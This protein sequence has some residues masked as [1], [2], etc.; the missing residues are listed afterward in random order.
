VIPALP[1]LA[2]LLDCSQAGLHEL[3]LSNLD[4]SAKCLKRAKEEIDQAIAHR[5]AA[6]VAR[7][8][9]ENRDELIKLAKRV[10][11]GKQGTLKFTESAPVRLV[12]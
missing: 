10:A 8:L 2:Y 9:I 1:N 7:W 12:A 6:G 11:D 5:E 3:E 4:L